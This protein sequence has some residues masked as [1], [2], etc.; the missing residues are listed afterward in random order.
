MSTSDLFPSKDDIVNTLQQLTGRSNPPGHLL[1]GFGIF[2][3]GILAGAALAVLFAP[4]P[5]A[6]LRQE[7]GARVGDLR[8]K[9]TKTAEGAAD[10]S[11]PA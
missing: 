11:K 7:I 2:A 3:A 6:E 10:S 9:I 5:G 1:A 8:D 4:K